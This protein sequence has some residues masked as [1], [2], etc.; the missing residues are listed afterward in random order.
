MT[1]APTFRFR[2][3]GSR[4]EHKPGVMNKTEAE[5]AALL[6]LRKR[7]GGDIEWYVFEAITFKLAADTRYTPDFI[8]MRHDGTLECHEVKGRKTS[9]VTR[10]VN[11]VAVTVSKEIA[12]VT[13]DSK[14][15]IKLAADKFP[16]RFV[17]VFPGKGG[18]W[19]A[20]EY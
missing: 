4:G 7:A 14:I 10:L 16:F 6:E 8:V 17:M 13:D 19:N 3:K 11:G 20:T 18:G 5:Y 15:K 12:Y 2:A 1:F 9:K